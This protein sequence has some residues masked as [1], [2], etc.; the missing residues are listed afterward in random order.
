MSAALDV[1]E[2]AV[3][4]R[5]LLISSGKKAFIAGADITEFGPAFRQGPESIA[6][7]LDRSNANFNRLEDLPFPVVAAINGF[8]LG[9]GCELALACDYRVAAPPPVSACLKPAW[10]LFRLGRQRAPA[11]HC[12]H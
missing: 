1:L 11:P 7:V 2:A 8:A 12:R 5:G 9:G 4:I 3:D 10:E 6:A